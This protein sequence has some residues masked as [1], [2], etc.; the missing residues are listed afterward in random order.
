[1]TILSGWFT[2]QTFNKL[3]L[4]TDTG[5]LRDNT[6]ILT[7]ILQHIKRGETFLTKSL[8]LSNISAT[9]VLFHG[10]KQQEILAK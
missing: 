4:V 6:R 9:T 7:Y 8:Q 10:L 3:Q 1:M 2:G 5:V